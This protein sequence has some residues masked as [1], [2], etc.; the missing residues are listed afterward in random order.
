M[1]QCCPNSLSSPKLTTF[2]KDVKE[3]KKTDVALITGCVALLI[4]GAAASCGAFNFIGTTNAAYLSYGMYA[5]SAIF[6]LAEVGKVA[7]GYCP[8]ICGNNTTR[9]VSPVPSGYVAPED[10]YLAPE[11]RAEALDA[12]DVT[13]L[14]E[15]A[16]EFADTNEMYD[17]LSYIIDNKQ[18][19]KNPLAYMKA[20]EKQR[21]DTEECRAIED[22]ARLFLNEEVRALYGLAKA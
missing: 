4:I 8:K 13:D 18:F 20:W 9:F 10:R 6:L 15:A 7:S 14:K 22:P 3:T 19:Q 16:K 11:D 21:G 5:G 17:Y 12:E 1:T 2:F